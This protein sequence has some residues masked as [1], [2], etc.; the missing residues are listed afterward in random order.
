MHQ[1]DAEAGHTPFRKKWNTTIARA[2]TTT[3]APKCKPLQTSVRRR[4]CRPSSSLLREPATPTS[5]KNDHQRRPRRSSLMK[6]TL[7]YAKQMS[8]HTAQIMAQIMTMSSE[9]EICKTRAE[10]DHHNRT[11]RPRASSPQ[12]QPQPQLRLHSREDQHKGHGTRRNKNRL[13][14]SLLRPNQHSSAPSLPCK[15]PRRN[16]T[17]LSISDT[18]RRP[19]TCQSRRRARPAH[20]K[21][22][23]GQRSSRQRPK[24]GNDVETPPP[25]P[26]PRS[27][28]SPQEAKTMARRFVGVGE[29]HGGTSTEDGRGRQAG[30]TFA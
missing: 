22:E 2:H 14:K 26:S 15:P 30:Q 5:P 27:R 16:P 1:C 28:L 18:H 24:E 12:V 17:S 9:E 20:G 11:A 8:L 3:P 13:P 6:P 29:L 7:A 21:R 19:G 10:G 4:G 25:D 23:R